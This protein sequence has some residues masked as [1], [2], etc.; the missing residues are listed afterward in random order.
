MVEG[1]SR[2][3]W[4]DMK[5]VGVENSPANAMLLCPGCVDWFE[6]LGANPLLGHIERAAKQHIH[7]E[8]RG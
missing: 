4:R 6:H 8:H 3:E 1:G 2:V 5:V 7:R